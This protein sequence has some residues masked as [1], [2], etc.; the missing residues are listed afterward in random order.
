MHLCVQVHYFMSL[1]IYAL[2]SPLDEL[3][4]QLWGPGC[5]VEMT[6]RKGRI[7]REVGKKDQ[8]RYELRDSGSN[9]L[10]SLNNTE[11]GVLH[12]ISSNYLQAYPTVIYQ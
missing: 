8:V 2:G 6:G 4:D 7:V 5:V 11:V 12:M 10:E 9:A 3:L 1:T